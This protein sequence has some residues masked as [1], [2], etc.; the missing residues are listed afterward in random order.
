MKEELLRR[1]RTI[2]RDKSYHTVYQPLI[3][4]RDS[5]IFGY[6]ALARFR[7][8]DSLIPPN[9]VF[10]AL[11]S[12]QDELGHLETA[13][14]RLQLRHAP[15]GAMIFINYDPHSA[16]HDPTSLQGCLSE[17]TGNDGIVFELIEDI[18]ELPPES[19]DELLLFLNRNGCSIAVDD[20]GKKSSFFSF[21]LLEFA[22]FVK[23]DLEWLFLAKTKENYRKFL[24]SFVKFMKSLEKTVV[25]EG[26]ESREDLAFAEGLG[27]DLVQG[28]LF[29]EMF[30]EAG[31]D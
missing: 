6:E 4:I 25:L 5:K 7:Y 24:F 19:L 13:V 28:F 31:R 14:T 22:D 15:P 10:E 3:K 26:V 2:V 30:I 11:H 8:E 16:V 21:R 29:K 1:I 27:V 9:I 20:F 17:Y 23:I 12:M 18:H